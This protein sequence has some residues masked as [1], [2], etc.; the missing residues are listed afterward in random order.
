VNSVVTTF[1]SVEA[2][3]ELKLDRFP[4]RGPDAKPSASVLKD[5]RA[6]TALIA[7]IEQGYVVGPGH[8]CPPGAI[9]RAHRV[10]SERVGC[11]GNSP[12]RL[13]EETTDAS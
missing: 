7:V 3:I 13:L 11:A 4:L 9:K 10:R 12:T 6:E 1:E 8:C 5:R 2:A